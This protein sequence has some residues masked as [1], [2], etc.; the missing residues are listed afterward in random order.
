[1]YCTFLWE[2][3]DLCYFLPQQI[4]GIKQRKI[5][6]QKLQT[7]LNL[8][9]AQTCG[10]CRVYCRQLH[11]PTADSKLGVF[12]KIIFKSTLSGHVSLPSLWFCLKHHNNVSKVCFWCSF[13][14]DFTLLDGSVYLSKIPVPVVEYFNFFFFFVQSR[15]V[16]TNITLHVS[17]SMDWSDTDTPDSHRNLA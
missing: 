11:H 8:S 17:K 13:M 2:I 7:D 6:F 14:L 15:S 3:S 16:E 1:M 9:V 5:W 10:S 4:C 12:S